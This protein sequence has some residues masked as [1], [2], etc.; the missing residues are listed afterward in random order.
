M[1]VVDTVRRYSDGLT[2]AM[3]SARRPHGVMLSI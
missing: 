2:A 3:Q 1:Y